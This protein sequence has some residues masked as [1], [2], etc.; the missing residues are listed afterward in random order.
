MIT[1]ENQR[2]ELV[3]A[4]YAALNCDD[5]PAVLALFSHD[6]TRV[7]T[8]GFPPPWIYRGLKEIEAHFRQGRGTWAEGGCEPEKIIPVGDRLVVLT[9]VK[10][11]LKIRPDWID[12]HTGDVFTFRGGRIHEFRTFMDHQKAL[13]WAEAN[14]AQP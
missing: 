8:E 11:R 4:L 13:A 10:V 2:F 9:H 12:G 1:Q 5:I 7:E 3:K 14:P 6:A